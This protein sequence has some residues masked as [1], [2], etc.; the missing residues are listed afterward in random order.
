MEMDNDAFLELVGGQRRMLEDGIR[1]ILDTLTQD[2]V[3]ERVETHEDRFL[4]GVLQ[5]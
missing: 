3:R 5:D 2:G 1:Q 4:P